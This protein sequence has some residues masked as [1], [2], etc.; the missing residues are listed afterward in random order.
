[1]EE[2]VMEV[3]MKFFALLIEPLVHGTGIRLRGE[4][5]CTSGVGVRTKGY[6]LNNRG[7]T[8]VLGGGKLEGPK[9]KSWGRSS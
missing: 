9:L 6:I 5:G 2:G 3:F 7:K 8:V 4:D 1:M